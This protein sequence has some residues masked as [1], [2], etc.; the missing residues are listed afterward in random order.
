MIHI[1]IKRESMR[2]GEGLRDEDWEMEGGDAERVRE[3][4][5]WREETER[6]SGRLG[7][8]GRRQRESQG[9]WEMEGG[10][11]ERESGR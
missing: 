4:G 3:I 8:G 2:L 6:G 9:D 7:D 5:R 10:D 11:R 1:V